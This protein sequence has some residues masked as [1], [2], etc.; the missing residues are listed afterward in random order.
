MP[1]PRFVVVGASAA[2]VSAALA[3]RKAGFDGEVTVID[4]QAH[5]PYERPP[6]SK[7]LVDGFAELKP[8]VRHEEIVANAIDLR[9]DQRVVAISSAS[10]SVELDGGRGLTAEKVLLATGLSARQLNVPGRDLGGVLRLRDAA[11]AIALSSHLAN[12]DR[13]V[14]I[15]AGFIGLELAAVARDSGREVT[16]IEIGSYPLT[17]LSPQVGALVRRL[18][19]E[20]GVRFRFEAS[21]ERFL[22][23]ERVHAVELTDG[24][25]LNAETVVVGVGATPRDDL[26]RSAGLE[27]ANGIV[28]DS[29]GATSRSAIFAAGDIAVQPHPSLSVPTRIEHWDSAMRHGAAVGASMA[30]VP[31]T[32]TDIP[33]AWSDQFGDTI[34]MF[35]RPSPTDLMVMRAD[36]SPE[37]F[38]GCWMHGDEVTAVIGYGRSRDTRVVKALIEERRAMSPDV[39]RDETIE[40]RDLRKRA[41]A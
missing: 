18:H 7:Q 6:L 38:L 25:V 3:M 14:V 5:F 36:S 32:F 40:L 21:V 26:A 12:T 1:K 35:G 24:E 41:M 11:D 29:H 4:S 13:L 27:L 15:G 17:H 16:V 30:G 20:R 39:I 28:V 31:T 22:G 9:L 8:I 2:G 23:S 34:Q 10:G 37:S 19:E 33:Y